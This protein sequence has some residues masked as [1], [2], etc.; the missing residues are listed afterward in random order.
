MTDEF[1]KKRG[2]R[3]KSL[4]KAQ[5]MTQQA[6]ANSIGIS[7]VALNDKLAG[8]KTLTEKNMRAIAQVLGVRMEYLMLYDD[9]PTPA[10]QFAQ[11]IQQAQNE[12]DLMFA[13]LTC[14]A[15]LSDYR[16]IPPPFENHQ[17]I[18]EV[19]REVR[20]GYRIKKGDKEISLSL[21]EMN[22]FENHVIRVIGN[23]LKYL[24]D[25]YGGSDN[26]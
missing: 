15:S 25:I 2:D 22:S 21:A 19:M 20:L 14:F 4:L 6:L 9:C 7:P 5:G 10:A 3:V 16:I 1:T 24:F 26:G 11:A 23:E 17:P 8:R 12:S 18:E 13:G